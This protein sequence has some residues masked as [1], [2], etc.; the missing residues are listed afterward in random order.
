MEKARTPTLPGSGADP[1]S[2]A[3]GEFLAS[4][5]IPAPQEVPKEPIASPAR[6]PISFAPGPAPSPVP[7][8]P[9]VKSVTPIQRQGT[10]EVSTPTPSQTTPAVPRRQATYAN[11]RTPSTPPQRKLNC[12]S[13]SPSIKNLD[14]LSLV[15]QRLNTFDD[16]PE[17]IKRTSREH[18][19]FT[20]PRTP[21]GHRAHPDVTTEELPAPKDEPSGPGGS[22]DHN[23]RDPFEF[24]NAINSTSRESRAD[25][26]LFTLRNLPR[27]G[28][29]TSLDLI[30]VS[31]RLQPTENAE[32]FYD[33]YMAT[34]NSLEEIKGTIGDLKEDINSQGQTIGQLRDGIKEMHREVKLA[35]QQPPLPVPQLDDLRERMIA[36][37]GGLHLVDV[38][39][40]HVKLDAMKD[41]L[42][43]FDIAGIKTYL[44]ELRVV[45]LANEP[46]LS[47]ELAGKLNS[48]AGK[49]DVEDVI[50]RLEQLQKEGLA[51]IPLILEKVEALKQQ[52]S[53]ATERTTANIGVTG[54]PPTPVMDLSSVHAKLD[55]ISALANSLM[56]QRKA[57]A[58]PPPS[59]IPPPSV[60][61][62][63]SVFKDAHKAP[64]LDSQLRSNEAAPKS[65]VSLDVRSLITYSQALIDLFA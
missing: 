61:R 26:P 17:R 2:R 54:A 10:L 19:Y 45:T 28:S 53:A 65:S 42:A 4:A 52:V 49:G 27:Q 39:G 64:D 16:S 25:L 34:N 5:A 20:P 30:S 38:P 1:S 37:A 35:I 15:K 8:Q 50:F 33:N 13:T 59:A 58:S 60:L 43:A 9:P 46:A 18:S 55:T 3:L 40:L 22:V 57:P 14:R 6:L 11:S 7:R 47:S 41:D 36:M 51:N 44:E 56:E 48:L 23:Y 31:T 12:Y 24:T 21:T 32:S 63:L 62:N 29:Q